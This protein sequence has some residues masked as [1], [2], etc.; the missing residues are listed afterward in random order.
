MVFELP[1]LG[2]KIKIETEIVMKGFLPWLG[3]KSQ[4]AKKLSA[5]INQVD[6]TCYVE[7]FM[8]A[9]HVF[10]RKDPSKAEVLNDINRDLSTLFRVLQNH[11]EEFMRYFKW[12]LVSRDEFDRL[13]RQPPDSLT[14]IQR[15]CR[16]YYLQKLA[17]GGKAVGR[18]YGTATTSPPRL[19]L[20][21]MGEELT[22]VH[23]RLARVNIENLPWQK[24]FKKYDR[25]HT[26][27]YIDPPYFNCETDYGKD[28]FSKKDFHDLAGILRSLEGNFI[29]SL[30]DTPETR[31]LFQGFHMEETQVHYSVNSSRQGK[32]KHPELIISSSELYL[33]SKVS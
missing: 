25:P 28:M 19:N 15:A 16:F 17:F 5:Y 6:H 3:G 27:F 33:M 14:D 23:L 12:A 31:K 26:L 11:F 4:L 18:T 8:G 13:N 32:K 2:P 22:Q 24:I 10:F 1:D 20:P 30:N 29:L 7:P 9:A 21:Y